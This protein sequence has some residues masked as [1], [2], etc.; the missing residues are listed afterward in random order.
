MSTSSGQRALTRAITAGQNS[1]AGG[2]SA[3]GAGEHLVGH[4]HRHVA[5]QPVALRTE[6][7]E[8]VGH[9][10]AQAGRERVELHHVRP[11]RESTGRGRAR[12]SLRRQSAGTRPGRAQDPPRCRPRSTPGSRPAMGDRARRGWARSRGSAPSPRAASCARASASP[13]GPPKRSSTT[14]S[15]TQYGDP[16]TSSGSRS[17]RVERKPAISPGSSRAIASPAGERR[18]TPISQTASTGRAASASHSAAGTAS[19][20]RPP[21]HTAVL[22]S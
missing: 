18:Q 5:A 2:S 20:V 8:Q 22:I 6:F 17:A 4:E 16:I 7:G 9:G 1:S 12:R 19:S 13:S 3:P 11:W 15:R 14:Y 10:V 21:S